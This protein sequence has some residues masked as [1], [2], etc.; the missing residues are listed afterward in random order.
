MRYFGSS[1]GGIGFSRLCAHFFLIS[2]VGLF[3]VWRLIFRFIEI[4]GLCVCFCV[5]CVSVVSF[6][7]DRVLILRYTVRFSVLM[8]LPLLCQIFYW[9]GEVWRVVG[10]RARCML[11]G[12][13]YVGCY[14]GNFERFG[15]PLYR[16]IE[17][18]SS[19]SM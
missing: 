16:V 15:P 7:V 5:C 4:W 2:Y 3:N 14:L 17:L 10:G 1:A 6:G 12:R 18:C 8:A 11:D 13:A 9:F 19:E